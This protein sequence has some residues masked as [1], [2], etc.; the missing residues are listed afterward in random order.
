MLDEVKVDRGAFSCM[1]G[2]DD[3]SSLFITT[4]QWFGMDRMSEMAGTDQ[5]V[6]VDVSVTGA[7]WPF[8]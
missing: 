1:L 3:R 7:G 4:A 2:G 8:N 5:I 6:S